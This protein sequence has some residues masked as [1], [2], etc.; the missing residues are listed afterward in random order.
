[1]S[2]AHR[3]AMENPLIVAWCVEATEFPDLVSR[4]RVTGVPKTVVLSA[5]DEVLTEILGAA[6]ESEFVSQ[7]VSAVAGDEG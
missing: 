5:E 3:M 2:L 1:M 4:H 6:P 7:I